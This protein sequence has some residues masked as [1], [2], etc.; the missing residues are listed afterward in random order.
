MGW[1]GPGFQ[2]LTDDEIPL[3]RRFRAK[4]VAV[5]RGLITWDKTEIPP[6]VFEDRQEGLKK[7]LAARGLPGIVIYSDLWR[8]N[9]AR[10]FANYMPYF[11]RALLILPVEGKATLLCGLSP[12]TY[13]WIQSVTPIED[14]RSAGNFVKPLSEIAAERSWTKV[15]MLD[16]DQLPYDLSQTL[17]SGPVKLVNV[18]SEAVYLPANHGHEIAMRRKAAVTGRAALAETIPQGVGRIDYE[19]VGLLERRLRLAG[20]EDLVVVLSNGNGTP[21]PACGKTLEAGF[22]VSIALE[23]RGHWVRLSSRETP[24]TEERLDGT[25][26]YECLPHGTILHRAGATSWRGPKGWETL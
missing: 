11:N 26:P 19:F 17:R 9:H 24:A 5:K 12:R 10:F 25:Y 13:R 23:Y 4:L 22:F 8:S 7:V 6:K 16:L 14:V 21:A 20:A 18:D 2:P 3:C 15:G 1:R